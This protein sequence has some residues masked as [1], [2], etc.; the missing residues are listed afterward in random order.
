L[1]FAAFALASLHGWAQSAPVRPAPKFLAGKPDQQEGAQVLAAFRQ[2]G[3]AGHYW[4]QFELRVM[5]RRGDERQLAGEMFGSPGAQGSLTRIIVDDVGNKG[6]SARQILLLQGAPSWAA[7]GWNAGQQG[8]TPQRLDLEGSLAPI[9]ETDLTAFDLQMPFLSWADAIYEGVANVRGRPAHVF[10]L[11]PPAGFPAAG[12]AA[13]RVFL[14][15]QF[16]AM[17]QAEWIDAAGKPTKTVTV[18]DLKKVGEQ[19]VVRS[20]D[21]RNHRTRAKTRL[22]LTA[23]ALDL[24]AWPSDTFNPE[25]ISRPEP[26]VPADRVERF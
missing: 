7:W 6:G 5:P 25:A 10:L 12:P 11:Y 4:A 17:T 22:S 8:V 15:T 19:W 20:I 13:V 14:D 23:V 18:L 1:F 9:H 3:I 24:P 16:G 2:V 26:P 21:L